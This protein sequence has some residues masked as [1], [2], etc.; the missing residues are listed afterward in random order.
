[1]LAGLGVIVFGLPQEKIDSFWN[2][3]LSV[4]YTMS[5]FQI[6]CCEFIDIDLPRDRKRALL[7]QMRD[8]L[9]AGME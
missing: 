7:K 3:K 6:L 1:M 4:N 8:M 2:A 9:R 5:A